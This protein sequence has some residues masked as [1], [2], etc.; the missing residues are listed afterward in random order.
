MRSVS[1]FDCHELIVYNIHVMKSKKKQLAITLR[2]K[3]Y[4]VRDIA[5]KL[6]AAQGSVS[7]WVSSVILS[8]EQK[9]R[10]KKKCHSPEVVE[11]RR[12]SR[13]K[14]EKQKKSVA[15]SEAANTIEKIDQRL[16]KFIGISLYWGEGA[17]AK[18]GTARITNSDPLL[19]KIMVRFF[20]EICHVP[21]EKLKAHIHVHSPSAVKA[22][23]KYWSEVSGIPLNQF[24]KT[25]AIKSKSSKNVRFT[26]PYGTLE[27]GVND[28][29]LHLRILGWIQGIKL[30]S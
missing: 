19:I 29:T 25:Y 23:E 4:S 21:K 6:D 26:L 2:Q 28:V 13:L 9:E 7:T 24:Y 18:I 1:I 3:G 5:Q 10:L 11:K 20:K 14:N 12:Q 8:K 30:Q 15:I 27:V 17:K 22:A 16:L